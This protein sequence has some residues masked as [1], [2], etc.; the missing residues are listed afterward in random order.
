[1]ALNKCSITLAGKEG[2][3]KEA[4][5][6]DEGAAEKKEETEDEEEKNEIKDQDTEV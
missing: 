6:D 5:E 2:Q 1:M 4:H 3:L